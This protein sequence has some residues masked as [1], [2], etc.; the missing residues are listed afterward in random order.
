MGSARTTRRIRLLL[1]GACSLLTVGLLTA[2]WWFLWP[3][4]STPR[5]REPLPLVPTPEEASIPVLLS[6]GPLP[7]AGNS[8]LAKP[9]VAADRDLRVVVTAMKASGGMDLLRWRSTDGGR[10]WPEQAA[11]ENS[12]AGCDFL[13]DPWLATDHRDRYHLV[14]LSTSMKDRNTCPCV[15]RR[16]ADGGRTWPLI[17]RVAEQA[18]R[19]VLAVSPSGKRLAI[20]GMVHDPTAP[21]LTVAELQDPAIKTAAA[22]RVMTQGVFRSGDRGKTWQRLPAP[23]GVRHAVPFSTVIDDA[24][25]I[26]G[27]W[28]VNDGKGS[29]SIIGS[30]A[31]EG[32]T[33]SVEVL[34]AALQPDR[35]HPFNGGRF[36]VVALDQSG[37]LQVVYVTAGGAAL[38]ATTSRDWT[39]WSAPIRLSAEGVGGVRNPAIATAGDA[40]HAIW[41]ERNGERHQVRY[42]ANKNGGATW[43]DTLTLSRP[44]AAS[45]LVTEQGFHIVGE[46]DQAAITNDCAGTAHVVWAVGRRQDGGYAVWH[47]TVAWEALER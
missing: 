28:V 42:R 40:I 12:P 47:A 31:D 38:W 43:S 15:Y 33:W 36:P 3:D 13:A 44:H 19:P 14:H 37:R 46:D 25:R 27:A 7:G 24:G 22:N 20:I 21:P 16:S 29:Q 4:E 9:V 23:P 8:L 6:S 11:F 45:P 10:T 18:D 41:M 32:K 30:T 5:D 2:G 39:T 1:W 17:T 34:V 35:D 26:A